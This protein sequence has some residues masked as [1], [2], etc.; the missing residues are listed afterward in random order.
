MSSKNLMIVLLHGAL[1]IMASRVILTLMKAVQL[2]LNEPFRDAFQITG[3]R[4]LL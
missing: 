1:S 3:L 4:K 2:Q